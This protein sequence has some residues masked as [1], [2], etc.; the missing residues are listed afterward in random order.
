METRTVQDIARILRVS[1]NTV[2]QLCADR[3]LV[4]F[5]VGSGRGTIRVRQEDLDAFI[6]GVTV[7]QEVPAAP[8]P[9]PTKLK[10]LK[11]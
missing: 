5:R 3:R 8:K 10:H 6:A 7:Q 2:Y 4:H 11:V 1:V 9:S